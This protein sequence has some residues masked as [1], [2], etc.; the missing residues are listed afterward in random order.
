MREGAKGCVCVC[1][2]VGGGGS[3]SQVEEAFLSLLYLWKRVLFKA[4]TQLLS[5]LA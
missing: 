2:C 5:C 3:Q 1:V 4:T